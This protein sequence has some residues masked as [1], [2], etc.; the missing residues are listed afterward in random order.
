LNLL[1]T[2]QDGNILVGPHIGIDTH[3][4]LVFSNK[5]L[6]ATIGLQGLVIVDTDDAL[7]ICT[8]DREQEVREIVKR[9]KQNGDDQWL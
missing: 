3:N 6:I 5:R 7:L 1:P 9:L 2:D 4:C 8:K